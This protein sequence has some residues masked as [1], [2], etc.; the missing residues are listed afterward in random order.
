L[1]PWKLATIS[2]CLESL[3]RNTPNNHQ[4]LINTLVD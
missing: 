4:T 3:T 1:V 2:S